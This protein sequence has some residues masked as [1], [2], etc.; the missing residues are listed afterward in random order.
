MKTLLLAASL[1]LVTFPAA[2]GDNTCAGTI[3]VGSEWT[4]VEDD[5]PTLVK[6]NCRFKT[7]SE[8]GKRILRTCPNGSQCELHL[9]I[10]NHPKDYRRDGK[11]M[12]IVKWPEGGVE[13][14]WD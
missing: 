1:A 4:V 12:T 14:D 11:F 6:M 9:S 2:A 13:K 8:L 5:T 7:A 10:D 3:V